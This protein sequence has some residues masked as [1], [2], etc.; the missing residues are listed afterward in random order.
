MQVLILSLAEL[1]FPI[2]V[3]LCFV[4]VLLSLSLVDV[5]YNC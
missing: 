4:V 5:K 3:D 2:T 1:F